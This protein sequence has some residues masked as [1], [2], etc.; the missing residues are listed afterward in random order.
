EDSSGAARR[1]REPDARRGRCRIR[2]GGHMERW[3]LLKD[4]LGFALHSQ[5]ARFLLDRCAGPPPDPRRPPSPPS[6]TTRPA[7]PAP[8]P[9]A[10]GAR[11][12]PGPSAS[13][14]A[15]PAGAPIPLSPQVQLPRL[16]ALHR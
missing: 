10:A 2:L 16:R 5:L 7:R 12:P 4:R 14:R 6:A 8:L 15:Q 11:L 1:R 9:A 13:P 3:C